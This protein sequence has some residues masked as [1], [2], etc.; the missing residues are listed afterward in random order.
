[1]EPKYEPYWLDTAPPFRAAEVEPI[2]GRFDVAV[3][4][5]G[6]TGLS[7]ALALRRRGATVAVLE[8]GQVVA[9]A[10]GRNGGQCNNGLAHGFAAIVDELGLDVARSFYLAYNAAV[11]RVERLVAEE[12]IDCDFHRCGKLKLAAKPTH[13]RHLARDAEL[14]AREI[15]SDSV[16]VNQNDLS[17]EIGSDRF[18]GAL[19]NRRSASLHVGRFGIGLAEAA[20]RQGAR[21][22][23]DAPVTHHQ[24]LSGGGHVLATTRGSLEADQVLVAT[25]AYTSGPFGWFRRRFV[26][27]GSFIIVTEPLETGTLDSIMPTR[28]NA[29]TTMTI[30]HY[31]RT[32]TD[33]RLIFGGRARFALSSQSSDA[34]SGR[35]LERNM[36]EIFPQLRGTRIDYCWGGLIDVV[37]DRLPHAGVHKDLFYAMGYSGHGVQMSVHMGEI[38]ADI[39]A[40]RT[41]VNPWRDLPWPAIPGHFGPPWFLPFIGAYYRVVNLL[42]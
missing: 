22:Y 28:R 30:G 33:N 17:V 21:V 29:T 11:D 18:Y 14:L 31:F 35:I 3:V 27:I 10:S 6:F 4:G 19:L 15:D 38:M 2:G 42:R 40:G 5:G 37:A 9:A 25:G 16:I 20:A 41:E 7:A 26:P 12:A 36:L 39:M 34:R 24:R 13:F 8:A 32:S 23:E 1:M